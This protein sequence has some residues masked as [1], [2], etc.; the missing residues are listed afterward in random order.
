[1]PQPAS[2]SSRLP[3][4]DEQ[5][6]RED[7]QRD[8]REV[9]PLLVLAVHV[10]DRV[11]DDQRADAGDDQHHHHAQLVDEQ[12]EAEVV[13]A[14]PTSHVHDVVTCAR[15]AGSSPHIVEE[16]DDGGD[17]RAHRRQRRDVAGERGARCACRRA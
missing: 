16:R 6:H 10:A 7:E 8:V 4:C 9:A 17:E 2:S 1:M 12:R 3:P 14:R 5:Q 13:L 15:D 11:G